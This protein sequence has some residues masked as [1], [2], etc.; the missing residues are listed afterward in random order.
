MDSTTVSINYPNKS[1]MVFILERVLELI[2]ESAT[3][4]L[5]E[6][7]INNEI[8]LPLL[9]CD[10]SMVTGPAYSYSPYIPPPVKNDI[11]NKEF[12]YNKLQRH[13]YNLNFNILEYRIQILVIQNT[14][15]ELG[16]KSVT[17]YLC[18]SLSN[19]IDFDRKEKSY[20]RLDQKIRRK[21]FELCSC[22]EKNFYERFIF[23]QQL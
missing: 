17:L 13:T 21:I 16:D 22:E 12:A 23:W 3:I 20:K 2:I 15:L 1:E 6:Y 14:I 11:I 10:L 19:E 8:N 4:S 5:K 7:L 9:K 18:P